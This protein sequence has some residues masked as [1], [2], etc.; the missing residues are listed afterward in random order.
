MI[1]RKSIDEVLER[2]R[3]EEVVGDFVNLKR[4]GSNLIGLCPFHNEKTPSFSVSPTRNI[5]KCF[6]C[7][8]VGG[9]AQFVME[10]ERYDFPEAIRY[11]ANK[12]GVQLEETKQDA[13]SIEAERERETIYKV[14][15]FAWQFYKNQLFKTEEGQLSGLTYFQERG[16]RTKTIENFGLGY[17]SHAAD[18]LVSQALKSGFTKEILQRAGLMT[19]GDGDFFRHRVIFPIFNISGKVIAFAGRQLQNNKR[20][21]KYINSPETEIYQKRKVLYGLF[22]AKKAIRDENNCFL[23]EGYTDVISLHQAGI[24]NVVASSGTSLTPDQIRLIRRYAS[25]ITVL[26]DSDVAGIKAAMRGL[27]LILEENMD[28]RIVLLPESEDPDSFVQK[29]G[30]A[31]FNE[32]IREN[33]KDFILFKTNLL[34]KEAGNDPVRKSALIKELVESLARI[35]E[36]IKRATFTQECARLMKIEEHI[37]VRE[38]NKAVAEFIQQKRRGIPGDVAEYETRTQKQ[39]FDNEERPSDRENFIPSSITDQYQ[40][41]DVIRILLS[42]GDK[43]IPDSPVNPLG[44][45]MIAS[46][47][48]IIDH[49]EHSVYKKIIEEYQAVL[50]KGQ[51]PGPEYFTNHPDREIQSLTIELLTFPF[52]YASWEEHD[53]PMQIQLHPDDNFKKDAHNAIL[54]LKLKIVMNHI[55]QN[56]ARLAELQTEGNDE[57]MIIHIRLHYDLLQIREQITSQFKNVVLKV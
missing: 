37:L 52:E 33:S 42:Y 51:L 56:Q 39:V 21:P 49:F 30:M 45:Y 25:Q 19:Q 57:E 26:Y 40:E 54:R 20:S 47:E 29:N 10:H 32:Y 5:Y 50:V 8:K 4:R 38:T 48:D 17:S 35:P 18:G 46:L 1:S 16:F 6:G 31:G 24:E 9:A 41:R 13:E 53:I 36:A 34:L 55:E 7:G 2:A 27:D 22:H 11:L 28:V 15:E 14:L 23:V 12:Y 43:D 44:R 3:I